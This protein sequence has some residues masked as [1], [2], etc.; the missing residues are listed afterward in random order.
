MKRTISITIQCIFLAIFF[1]Y[2][3]AT[4]RRDDLKL[5]PVATESVTPPHPVEVVEAILYPG[6]FALRWSDDRVP[7]VPRFPNRHDAEYALFHAEGDSHTP[8]GELEPIPFQPVGSWTNNWHRLLASGNYEAMEVIPAKGPWQIATNPP[9]PV[10]GL[11]VV[12]DDIPESYIRIG[13]V[14]Y[15]AKTNI[16]GFSTLEPVTSGKAV[17]K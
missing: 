16:S 7:W 13:G 2:G 8:Y 15:H 14:L 17:G 9:S 10:P 11:R 3:R 6:T 5:H 1:F 4:Q 12:M